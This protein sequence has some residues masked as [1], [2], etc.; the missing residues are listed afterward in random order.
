M[1]PTDPGVVLR[2]VG[3]RGGT[4]SDSTIIPLTGAPT[5]ELRGVHAPFV[6]PVFFPMRLANVSYFG[7]LSGS[8]GTNLLVTPA[9]HRVA[10]A[11]LGTSTLRRYSNLDLRLF[12]SGNLTSAALSDAP[13]IVGIEAQPA[14]GGV[15]FT[16][17]VVGD[18]A[19]AIHSVWV[20]YA[21]GG[22]TWAPLD[23]QQ[24]VAPLPAACG[25][26][27]DSRLWKGRLAALPAD[28]QYVAQAA[29]GLG[30][31]SLDDNR[32]SYYRLAGATPAAA[33]TLALVSPP[34]AGTFGDSPTVTAKLT[35]TAGGAPIAGK[36][37]TIGIGGSA[38]I[39]TTGADGRVTL[40][41]PLT[42]VPGSH[43]L[44]ASFAGD[45]AYLPSSARKPFAIAKAQSTLSIFLPN[46]IVTPGGTTGIDPTLTASVGGKKQPLLQLTVTFTVF[47]PRPD[48]DV[49]DDHRL[50]RARH[51]AADRPRSRRLPRH[52]VVRG[53][54]HLHGRDAGE[55]A[56]DLAVHGL[57]LP[58]Q[59]PADAEH[60]QRGQRRPDQ[61][62]PGRLP[63]L[64]GVRTRLAARAHD[65]LHD[66]GADR[67]VENADPPG[68]SGLDYSD[69]A[70]RYE[71]GWKTKKSW[72]GGCR[73]LELRLV[74]GTVYSAD[75]KLQ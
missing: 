70:D 30:L 54:R 61:V 10:D 35:Q 24:C 52:R 16:A 12:Y 43:Q 44:V 45:T 73:R 42:T 53:R 5:T 11:T 46:L 14:A 34:A 63:R 56:A 58:G 74:D 17:Q 57:P 59:E 15:D 55:R 8:G 37:V 19:A 51:A 40:Q 66:E 41:V 48:E 67:P 39:G 22:G 50:P 33:T 28:L 23:L 29:N 3:F 69:N 68:N 18:P 9:Q 13:T 38:A 62:Q 6:S 2:G 26:T 31:V 25:T 47:R 75:F 32:G 27:E 60:R 72:A 21:N 1:T 49:L 4:F 7:A 71:Y 36:T 64:P 20:T 65:Q